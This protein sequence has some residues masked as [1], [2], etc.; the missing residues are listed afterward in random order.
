MSIHNA[1]REIAQVETMLNGKTLIYNGKKVVKLNNKTIL[2][3][4]IHFYW[5]E[6]V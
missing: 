4:V 2:N 1:T 5:C 3:I 6:H